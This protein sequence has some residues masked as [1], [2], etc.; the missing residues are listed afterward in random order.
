[1]VVKMMSFGMNRRTPVF[2]MVAHPG[3]P[4]HLQGKN[5]PLLAGLGTRITD[6]AF[7]ITLI[8]LPRP[9]RSALVAGIGPLI[10]PAAR[11]LLLLPSLLVV[12]IAGSAQCLS[13]AP[14][15]FAQWVCAR[16]LFLARMALPA[17]LSA[18]TPRT[19]S[20]RA[21]DAPRLAKD[22]IVPLS[23][24]LG[25]LVASEEAVQSTLAQ[26]AISVLVMANSAFYFKYQP[27][28]IRSLG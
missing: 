8:R 5:A 10:N 4:L 3:P 14:I 28:P 21:V 13:H 24:A 15:A 17:N 22:R 26:V 2:L 19:N 1:M 12:M 27:R 20:S 11:S 23:K 25:M 6:A 9:I 16:A 18:L 7:R